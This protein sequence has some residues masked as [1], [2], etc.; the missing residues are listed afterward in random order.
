MSGLRMM[1]LGLCIDVRK[2][3]NTKDDRQM[4]K[5]KTQDKT[6]STIQKAKD[7]KE[8]KRQPTIETT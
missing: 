1:L 6:Q 7:K 2:V 5:P 3:Q 8:D 4:T